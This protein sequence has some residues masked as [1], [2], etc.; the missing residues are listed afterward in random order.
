M[1]VEHDWSD[2]TATISVEGLKGTVR[3]L[4]ATDPHVAWIDDRDAEFLGGC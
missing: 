1:K 2:D 3:M 4:H